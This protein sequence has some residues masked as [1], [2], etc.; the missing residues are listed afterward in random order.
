M[1]DKIKQALDTLEDL[2]NNEITAAELMNSYYDKKNGINK[3]RIEITAD[4]G[5][6]IARCYDYGT[7]EYLRKYYKHI[8]GNGYKIEIFDIKKR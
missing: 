4:D 1:N 3:H 8:F 7:P 2:I 5:R 6:K